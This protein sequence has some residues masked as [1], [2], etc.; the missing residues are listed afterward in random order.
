MQG[1]RT[2]RLCPSSCHTHPLWHEQPI[3]A[4]DNIQTKES[5]ESARRSR[6]RLQRV[7]LR[8]QQAYQFA[9]R[10]LSDFQFSWFSFCRDCRNSLHMSPSSPITS[11]ADSSASISSCDSSGTI[12]SFLRLSNAE[13]RNRSLMVFAQQ[14]GYIA[15]MRSQSSG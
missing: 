5:A 6:Q 10:I 3:R 4:N 7:V 2:V 1:P 8:V 15:W 13:S 9:F 14:S 11:A 12:P